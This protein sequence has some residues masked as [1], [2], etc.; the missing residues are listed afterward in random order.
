MQQLQNSTINKSLELIKNS[1]VDE[2]ETLLKQQLL[3]NP[4]QIQVLN[5]LGQIYLSK[6]DFNSSIDYLEKSLKLNPKDHL[7]YY[8]LGHA[9]QKKE[10]YEKALACYLEA[11]RLNNKFPKLY[12]DLGFL[13]AKDHQYVEAYKILKRANEHNPTDNDI[14][15]NLFFTSK[16]LGYNE[17]TLYYARKIYRANPHDKKILL[18]L[19][20]NSHKDPNMQ[21][22]DLK[23]LAEEYY[24]KFL[25]R[26]H[27]TK[28]F[29]K[30]LNPN[31]K[32][33]KIG[34]VS[35]DLFQ[36]P[37]STFLLRLLEKIN[38]EDFEIFLYY[39]NNRE[40]PITQELKTLVNHFTSLHEVE[41]P[42]AAK[43]IQDDEIDILFDLSGF[44]K[45]NRLEIFAYKPAP[46]QITYI[47][48]FGTLGMP[49]IDYLLADDNVIKESEKEFY[50]E[51]I[52]SL[53]PCFTHSSLNKVTQLSKEPAFIKND[54]ITF[55][56]TNRFHK[57]SE[58]NIEIWSKILRAV[59]KSKILFN[60]SL[61]ARETNK[62]FVYKTF[63]KYKVDKSRV[64]LKSDLIR[65][66]FLQTYTEVDIVLDSFPYGG[67]TTSL[68][69][70][71]NGVPVITID[72]D[73]W[74]SRMTTTKLRTI[75]H[76]ELIAKNIDEYVNK[77]IELANNKERIKQYREN[78]FEDIND[79]ELNIEKFTLRFE[80]ALKD[81]WQKECKKS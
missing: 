39:T 2:A 78:L 25:K 75:D 36:H 15:Q 24:E 23:K 17:E 81:I 1:K 29:S 31:K 66:D 47:G 26:E 20:F 50:T 48:Y 76:E 62:A 35:Y 70:L 13:L 37:V 49:E 14:I 73:R 56:C 80:K 19:I 63:A 69:S 79:S 54:F 59:P 38:K 40:D 18:S 64:I 21:H 8:Y 57:I 3:K 51:K 44:T 71:I 53:G 10:N 60:C 30:Q 7:M 45:G 33:L 43:K 16:K 68:E 42:D 11:Y 55:A 67:G 72:G 61:F 46:I 9:Y 65:D 32:T 77:A 12:K 4:S 28:D 41:N 6:D 34:F 5:I 27:L 52:Y 22:Q 58:Y 74:V